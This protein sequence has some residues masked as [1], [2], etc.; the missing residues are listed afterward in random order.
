MTH[1]A[2]PGFRRCS[3]IAQGVLPGQGRAVRWEFAQPLFELS[4]VWNYRAFFLNEPAQGSAEA[5]AIQS[6]DKHRQIIFLP[7]SS[8]VPKVPVATFSC[9][10]SVDQPWKANSQSWIAPAPFVARW[11]IQPRSIRRLMM[12]SRH[13]HQMRAVEEHHAGTAFAR[14]LDFGGALRDSSLQTVQGKARRE[15]G[16]IRI[17]SIG[18][19]SC[20]APRDKP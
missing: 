6:T 16:S 3:R 12:L 2:R 13:F 17:S 18:S 19:G 1:L 14:R 7:V 20:V 15:S 4:G 5:I 9:T 10:L 8:H 11:V